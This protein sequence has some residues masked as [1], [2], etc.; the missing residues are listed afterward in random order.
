MVNGTEK[1][2][3]LTGGKGKNEG[4]PTPRRFRLTSARGVRKELSGLYARMIND[5]TNP[6]VARVGAYVLRTRLEAIRLD[7]IEA[8]LK[9]LE[10]R[11]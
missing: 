4:A 7:V 11:Q 6:E 9:R 10:E 5:E 1:R 3:H 8:E 2:P